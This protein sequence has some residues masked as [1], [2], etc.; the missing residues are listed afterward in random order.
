MH[1]SPI[2]LNTYEI[3]RGKNVTGS[4]L[5]GV[6]PKVDIPV[7]AK[8]YLDKVN[9]QLRQQSIWFKLNNTYIYMMCFPN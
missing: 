4:L 3:L 6:K 1:G 5:G 8:K 2:S 7:F 9:L